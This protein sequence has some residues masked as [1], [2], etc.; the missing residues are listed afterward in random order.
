M[1]R[2]PGPCD[3]SRSVADAGEGRGGQPCSG[4]PATSLRTGG[5]GCQLSEGYGVIHPP[6]HLGSDQ[7]PLPASGT[8]GVGAD[9]RA[10]RAGWS[11]SRCRPRG[12]L[13]AAD[14]PGALRP[15]RWRRVPCPGSGWR[16]QSSASRGPRRWGSRRPPPSG[17]CGTEDS[18]RRLGTSLPLLPQPPLQKPKCRWLG[19]GRN[20]PLGRRDPEPAAPERLGGTCRGPPAAAA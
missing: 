9:C 3:V 2:H 12:P 16:G 13:P 7:G 20:E 17:R 11:G 4:P 6:A 15:L 18:H 10:F 19:P 5:L 14:P 1:Q 8:V